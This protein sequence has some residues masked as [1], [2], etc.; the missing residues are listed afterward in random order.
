[1][2]LDGGLNT[3]AFQAAHL[4]EYRL[5]ALPWRKRFGA[6]ITAARTSATARN[7]GGKSSNPNS[8]QKPHE[9]NPSIMDQAA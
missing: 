3:P 1:L 6:W 5:A 4:G 7:Q 8:L 9:R 2:A